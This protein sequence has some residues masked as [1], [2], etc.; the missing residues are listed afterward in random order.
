MANY[1]F[2]INK[3]KNEKKKKLYLSSDYFRCDKK[4][5]SCKITMGKRK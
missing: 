5:K 4:I 3:N 2:I 1:K